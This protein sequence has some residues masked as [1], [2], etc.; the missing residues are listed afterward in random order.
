MLC[1]FFLPMY[2]GG[3]PKISGIVT[4]IYLKYSYK[5]SLQSTSP[6][7]GSSDPSAAPYA[8]NVV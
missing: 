3:D 6:V 5:N 8:V 4:K 1:V 2:E 7:T